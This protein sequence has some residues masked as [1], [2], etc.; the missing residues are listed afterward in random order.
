LFFFFLGCEHQERFR[1]LYSTIDKSQY[2]LLSTPSSSTSC[3]P[4]LVLFVM[5][6]T[7]TGGT[8]SLL[9]CHVFS[10]PR[11][12]TAFELCDMIRKLIIKRTMSPILPTST[13]AGT[14]LL[15][16]HDHVKDTTIEKRTKYLDR[17]RPISA[18]EHRQA[19]IQIGI[20]RK[21][22]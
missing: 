13:T 8:C 5:R 17:D 18:M 20:E 14:T 3:H 2:N 12:S 4:P 15:R 16:I 10:V 11:E 22:C 19:D 6:K 1:P 9:D 7:G 21:V